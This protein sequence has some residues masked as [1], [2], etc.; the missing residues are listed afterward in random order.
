MHLALGNAANASGELAGAA[1]HHRD[2]L[3]QAPADPVLG[4]NYASVLGELGCLVEAGAAL[5]VAQA[6]SA[7]DARWS[8]QLRQTASELA[9]STATRSAICD[10]LR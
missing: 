3:Q 1:R 4:N 9:A 10:A 6:T 5:R 2:G 8:K 7:A